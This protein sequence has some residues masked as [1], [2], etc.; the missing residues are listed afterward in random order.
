MLWKFKIAK[1][2]LFQY[3]RW[4]P[5][6]DYSNHISS[7]TVSQIELKHDWGHRDSELLNTLVPVSKL[8][9]VVAILKVFKQHQVLDCLRQSDLIA[10][11]PTM[12]QCN[13]S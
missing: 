12:A 1:I 9:A 3:P 10:K 13:I 7:Q 8:V 4:P 6:L 2:L 11:M 5:S